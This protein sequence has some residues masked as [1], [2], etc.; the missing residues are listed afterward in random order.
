MPDEKPHT[1]W[2]GRCCGMGDSTTGFLAH[3]L[4]W[5]GCT[6]SDRQNDQEPE[7][8]SAEDEPCR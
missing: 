2:E 3:L 6:A 1:G 5:C 8:R 4:D 7:S